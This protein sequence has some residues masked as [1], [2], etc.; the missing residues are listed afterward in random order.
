VRDLCDKVVGSLHKKQDQVLYDPI[1]LSNGGEETEK[2]EG[3]VEED[4]IIVSATTKTLL[5]SIKTLTTKRKTKKKAQS[6]VEEVLAME[7]HSMEDMHIS[8]SRP[9]VLRHH[10]I[11]PFL[12]LLS[13]ELRP[14]LNKKF[15]P[16]N[17]SQSISTPHSTS[18]SLPSGLLL[19][20]DRWCVM[21]N[22]ER[23][24]SFF[25]LLVEQFCA[26]QIVEF[27]E[28]TNNALSKFQQPTFYQNP[29]PHVSLAW[30]VGDLA[31]DIASS[32]LGESFSA[33]NDDT[34]T[35]RAQGIAALTVLKDKGV[36]LEGELAQPLVLS[37]PVTR[38]LCTV[39]QRTHS[40]SFVADSTTSVNWLVA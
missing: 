33:T 22:E 21:F 5:S 24:R 23:T 28:A 27:I 32:L 15:A 7:R 20:F 34:A 6:S 11:S 9:V 29:K 4:D 3:E 10:Q 31:R 2:D 14:V 13:S 36:V 38:V 12:T 19:R 30:K 35:M 8:L 17:S 1:K 40:L 25:V 39:G 26:D 18:S 16:S 37:K